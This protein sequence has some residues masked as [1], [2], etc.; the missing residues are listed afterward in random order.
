MSVAQKSFMRYLKIKAN[1][2]SRVDKVTAIQARHGT[3]AKE[4]ITT[5]R[6]CREKQFPLP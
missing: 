5:Q 1:Y 2:T 4:M 6:N 3:K